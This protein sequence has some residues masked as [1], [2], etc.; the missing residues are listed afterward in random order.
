MEIESQPTELDQLERR[1]LQLT[2][3]RQALS[4]ESDSASVERLGKLEKEIGELTAKRN[5]MKLRW[6]GERRR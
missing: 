4:K 6:Q 5:A 1:L 2:I 3:E